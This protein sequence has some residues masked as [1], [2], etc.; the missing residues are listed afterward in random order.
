MSP[1]TSGN[2]SFVLV[3]DAPVENKST[4]STFV[5]P[6]SVA[7]LL[8]ASPFRAFFFLCLFDSAMEMLLS[9][10]R[11]LCRDGSCFAA[12]APETAA[13]ALEESTPLMPE[14]GLMADVGSLD[15]KARVLFP[16]TAPQVTYNSKAEINLAIWPTYSYL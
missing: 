2:F 1:S 13:K 11:C 12:A 8:E 10:R 14:S 3:L 16:F 7:K 6:I 15:V 4:A 5:F 9:T